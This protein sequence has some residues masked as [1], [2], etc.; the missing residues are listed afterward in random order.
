MG[1]CR[2]FGSKDEKEGKSTTFLKV[3]NVKWKNVS[4][5]RCGMLNEMGE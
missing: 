4:Y 3:K 2:D 5:T 1:I